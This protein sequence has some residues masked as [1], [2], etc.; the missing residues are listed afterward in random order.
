[1]LTGPF[2]DEKAANAFIAALKKAG[3]SGAFLFR[4]DAGEAVDALPGG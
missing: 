3:R 2:A 4:S 1:L